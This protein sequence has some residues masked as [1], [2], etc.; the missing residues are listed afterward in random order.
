MLAPTPPRSA[1][2]DYDRHI[3]LVYATAVAYLGKGHAAEQ[4][5]YEVFLSLFQSGACAP[6]RHALPGYLE[7]VTR[8]RARDAAHRMRR[9]RR[10]RVAATQPTCLAQA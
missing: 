10:G 1:I 7:I 5:C 4:V 8:L 6:P 2:R 3:R 9:Q